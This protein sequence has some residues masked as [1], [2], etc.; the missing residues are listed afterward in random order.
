MAKEKPTDLLDG[1]S[2][3]NDN[4]KTRIQRVGST[5]KTNNPGDGG[6]NRVSERDD[7]DD[8]D[9]SID[10]RK[11]T[12]KFK[13][14]GEMRLN[15]DSDDE[16]NGL[17]QNYYEQGREPGHSSYYVKKEYRFG[18]GVTANRDSDNES[19]VGSS[20]MTKDGA[21]R[22]NANRGATA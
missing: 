13:D 11:K 10:G 6:I 19:D 17:D 14:T 8:D 1:D 9:K 22:E 21:E 18:K 3:S 2:A 5:K 16:K 20:F 7:E 15:A 12:L 4:S